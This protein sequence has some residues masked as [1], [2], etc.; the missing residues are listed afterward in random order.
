M[1]GRFST[2]LPVET[3]LKRIVRGHRIRI[4]DI[5]SLFSEGPEPEPTPSQ[6]QPWRSGVNFGQSLR[7]GLQRLL[8][9]VARLVIGPPA[10]INRN[11][12]Q[13]KGLE[14][15]LTVRVEPLSGG[16]SR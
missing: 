12:Q 5:P 10:Q 3:P 1:Q 6:R 9:G 14:Q 13:F 2:T 15:V 11:G 16:R 8:Q 4:D 7:K